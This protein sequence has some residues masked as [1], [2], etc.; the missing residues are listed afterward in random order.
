[1]IE[2]DFP[3]VDILRLPHHQSSKHPPMSMLNRAAQFSP[4]A[5]LVGFEGVI[6]ETGRL[7]GR[8]IELSEGEKERM[9]QKLM[10]IDKA[11]RDGEN[12]EVTIRYF[13]PDKMKKGG[14]YQELTGRVRSIDAME[15]AVVFLA[16]NGRSKGKE[17]KIDNIQEIQGEIME[18]LDGHFLLNN[19]RLS[20]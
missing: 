6:A 13:V 14:S 18:T 5:A 17:I 8:K 9:N 4:Y 16:E 12:P 20:I 1:M 2:K 19:V 7:T 11:I 10:I 15:R 3:Y